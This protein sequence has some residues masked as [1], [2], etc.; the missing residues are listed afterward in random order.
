[1]YKKEKPFFAYTIKSC[2]QFSQGREDNLYFVIIIVMLN[3]VNLK[4]SKKILKAGKI[5]KLDCKLVKFAIL[6]NN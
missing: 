1:M 6:Y 5:I 4:K 3:N 2:S